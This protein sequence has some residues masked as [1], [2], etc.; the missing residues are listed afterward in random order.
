MIRALLYLRLTSLKNLVLSRFRRLKQPK[1]LLG[2]IAGLA[3]FWLIFFRHF[4]PNGADSARNGMDRA[5][6]VLPIAMVDTLGLVSALGALLLLGIVTLAWVLPTQKPGL[7]FTE[8]ETAFLFPAPVSRRMLINF[9][10]LSSQFTILFTS[11][12]FTLISSRW[13]SM[14]GNALTHAI[15][16]WVILS[17]LN[18]HFTGAALVITRLIENGV[19]VARRRIVV[20]GTIALVIA[21]TVAWVWRDLQSPTAADVA[22]VGAFTQYLAL[23]LNSGAMAVLLWPFRWVVAPFLAPTTMVFLVALGPALL[24]LAAEYFWVMRLQE[25][26]FEEASVSLAEKRA[27]KVAQIQQGK[28]QLGAE[29]AKA[30]PGPFHLKDT[31]WPELAFLWK[32]LLSTR[33]YFNLRTFAVLA[34]IILVGS[35][36]LPRTGEFGMA[37]NVAIVGFSLMVGIYTLLFG[38]YV[39]R[40]DLRSDLMNADVLKTYPVRGWRLV[41]GELLTPTII[42]TALVWLALLAAALV[43]TPTGNMAR[44]FT[45]ALQITCAVCAAFVAPFLIVLQ[46]LVLNGATLV[47]PGWFQPSR[48]QTG[49]GGIEVMGQRL[50]FALGN[51]LVIFAAVFPAVLIAAALIFTTQWLI[52]GPLAVLLATLAVLAVLVGEV[53]CG[54]WWLG[55]RFEKFDLSAELRP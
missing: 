40:Q 13:N 10:L 8:A 45:P 41:L 47:F 3:Y 53:W 54:L 11:F 28:F 48:A 50:I 23:G 24:V 25:V 21:A 7:G 1:Y 38:P 6:N 31:G 22:E 19:S 44:S 39:A 26:S 30:R 5:A 46:L 35:R 20:F 17:T 2:A 9:K 52:G 36:W 29:P 37:T 16:W 55:Q 49:G 4:V 12:F 42:L 32:N 51:L 33:S 14:G 34:A 18:L 15:G 43:F 27:A